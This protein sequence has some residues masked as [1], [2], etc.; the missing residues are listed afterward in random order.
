MTRGECL[1]LLAVVVV[2]LEYIVCAVVM[3]TR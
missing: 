1:W 2:P 3:V